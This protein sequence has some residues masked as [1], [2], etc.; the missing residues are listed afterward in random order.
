M[1]KMKIVVAMLGLA[2]LTPTFNS[3]KKEKHGVEKGITQLEDVELSGVTFG[4]AVVT[5]KKDGKLVT[6]AKEG[7]K[8]MLD[9]QAKEGFELSSVKLNGVDVPLTELP[10]EVTLGKTAPKLEVK[11]V[12]AKAL[13]QLDANVIAEHASITFY[14]GEEEVTKAKEGE[15]LTFAV[16]AERGYRITEVKID[17]KILATPYKYVVGT[18]SPK[19]ELATEKLEVEHTYDKIS[20]T[21]NATEKGTWGDNHV[22]L[23]KSE[24]DSY[25]WIGKG[26][27]LSHK[28]GGNGGNFKIKADHAWE[29]QWGDFIVDAG[30]ES[31]TAK[32][33]EN[34]STSPN[35]QITTNISGVYDIT[36][37]TKTLLFTY[38][39]VG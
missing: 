35:A 29:H 11:V 24:T 31:V 18:T 13:I 26:I 27:K 7:D 34:N 14:R 16:S 17:D 36:F 5:F 32:K 10:K 25:T 21:G 2:L 9:I 6:K 15:E 19:V 1:K 22:D 20:L 12:K 33:T 23:V 30:L 3:C 28:G 8:L 38:K 4:N 37:N 39:K